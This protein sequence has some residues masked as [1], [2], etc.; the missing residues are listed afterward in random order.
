MPPTPRSRP[1]SSHTLSVRLGRIV[2]SGQGLG[3]VAVVVLVLGLAV[4]AA[5]SAGD[6]IDRLWTLPRERVSR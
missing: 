1:K 5:P 4:I 6:V 3:V 2:I